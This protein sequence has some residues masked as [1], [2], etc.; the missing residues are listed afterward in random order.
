MP[1]PIVL[2]AE[3][4][5]PLAVDYAGLANMSL[6]GLSGADAAL[7]ATKTSNAIP[8]FDRNTEQ[9][10]SAGYDNNTA[11]QMAA[12]SGLVRGI[13]TVWSPGE[14]SQPLGQRDID[15][16]TRYFYL[17]RYVDH[18]GKDG[19]N[20]VV[21]PLSRRDEKFFYP[22]AVDFLKDRV[23][24]QSETG[25]TV[26]ERAA[27]IDFFV[28]R[29]GEMPGEGGV[30]AA[31]KAAASAASLLFTPFSMV[32]D[33]IAAAANSLIYDGQEVWDEHG[34][35]KI[36]GLAADMAKGNAY[37]PYGNGVL[38]GLAG[39]GEIPAIALDS[40]TRIGAM[41]SGDIEIVSNF[42]QTAREY[43]SG[44]MTVEDLRYNMARNVVLSNPYFGLPVGAYTSSSH[45]TASIIKGDK[46]GIAEGAFTLGMT[47]T[48]AK[49]GNF[50]KTTVTEA[51]TY[52][53]NG[54]SNGY[55]FVLG[56][57]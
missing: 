9:A 56:K 20:E 29:D 10:P 46:E 35:E 50:G 15:G 8:G 25:A 22:G 34:T 24:D 27:A 45:L 28:R 13:T 16:G 48:G 17:D 31:G 11:L 2:R 54:I 40:I 14:E 43:D 37:T 41:V 57:R 32:E 23:Y 19:Y 30:V 21:Q 3:D 1:A 39:A 33:R 5:G 26:Q 47:F 6:A 38:K 4:L 42:S 53:I 12:N 52:N 51:A 18:Y 36:H 55:N 44:N 7:P 49:I